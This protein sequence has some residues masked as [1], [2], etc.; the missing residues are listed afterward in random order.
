MIEQLQ[1][2]IESLNQ[3]ENLLAADNGK[4]GRFLKSE[5]HGMVN[6]VRKMYGEIRADQPTAAMQLLTLQTEERTL[7]K[8][9]EKMANIVE[10]KKELDK[11][12]E[13]VSNALELEESV[14]EP[15]RSAE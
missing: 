2:D 12:I 7:Q 10:R 15:L 9:I 5:L 1:K 6:A 3:W 11:Q 8:L 14:S 13:I 4:V